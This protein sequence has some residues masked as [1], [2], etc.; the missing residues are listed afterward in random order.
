[1]EF[2]KGYGKRPRIA[3]SYAFDGGRVQQGLIGSPSPWPPVML[4]KAGGRI[5]LGWV[6]HG[7]AV[8]PLDAT[9]WLSG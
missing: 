8:A 3:P 9:P 5:Q 2:G 6:E 7:L 1:M 4:S